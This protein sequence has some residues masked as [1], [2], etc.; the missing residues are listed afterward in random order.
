M[1]RLVLVILTVTALIIGLYRGKSNSDLNPRIEKS[2]HAGVLAQG[3]PTAAI[4]VQDVSRRNGRPDEPDRLTTRSSHPFP[5]GVQAVQMNGV[6]PPSFGQGI[7]SP[8]AASEF[9]KIF[10]DGGPS[11]GTIRVLG[12]HG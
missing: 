7:S 1:K 6:S 10:E 3:R 11:I 2:P 12:H 8:S 9:S 4:Q 5:N